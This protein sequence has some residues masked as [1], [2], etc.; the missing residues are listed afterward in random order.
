[1]TNGEL[2]LKQHFIEIANL[3]AYVNENPRDTEAILKQSGAQLRF[4]DEGAH[5]SA[6]TLKNSIKE[7]LGSI[8]MAPKMSRNCKIATYRVLWS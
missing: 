2:R 4:Q 1:M 7:D 8:T 5:E 3:Y 6:T